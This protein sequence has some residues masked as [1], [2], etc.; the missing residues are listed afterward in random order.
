MTSDWLTSRHK[1]TLSRPHLGLNWSLP[2]STGG[3]RERWCLG[4]GFWNCGSARA[5]WGRTFFGKKDPLVDRSGGEIIPLERLATFKQFP[6]GTY[7]A[8]L[9]RQSGYVHRDLGIFSSAKDAL[10]EAAKTFR[11]AKVHDVRITYVGE[12]ELAAYRTVYNLRGRAEGKKFA[13]VRISL[14][15]PASE[16][17]SQQPSRTYERTIADG[18]RIKLTTLKQIEGDRYSLGA[19]ASCANC[20]CSEV[21]VGDIDIHCPECGTILGTRAEFADA[22]RQLAGEYLADAKIGLKSM[23]ESPTFLGPS[24]TN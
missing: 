24:Q 16:P 10:A 3:L 8:V 9:I 1:L 22:H 13:G 6:R 7:S 15:A 23:D 19:D 21:V 5:C 11:R 20:G 4:L 17:Q 18:L 2:C 12:T 14:V